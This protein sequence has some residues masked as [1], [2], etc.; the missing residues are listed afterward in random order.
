MTNI[1]ITKFGYGKVYAISFGHFIHDIYTSFLAPVLPLL[2]DKLKINYT[3]AALLTVAMRLPSLFNAFAGLLADKISFR[4]MVILA[5]AFSGVIMS[6]LGLAPNYIVLLL[7]LFF[8]GVSSTVFH[9]PTPVMIKKALPEKIGFGMSMYMLGGE[10]ARTFGPLTIIA[11]ISLWG[12]ENA[13]KLV[14]LAIL[15][16]ALLWFKLKDFKIYK[17]KEERNDLVSVKSVLKKYK[18]FFLYISGF[19]LFISFM[20]ASLSIFLPTFITDQGNSLWVGGINLAIY[21][22]AGAIGT[23]T[24][25]TI[26]DKI[27]RKNTLLIAAISNPLLM[28]VYVYFQDTAFSYIFLALLGLTLVSSGSVLLAMVQ[29][30]PSDRPA[31]M[32]GIYMTINFF[33]GSLGAVL[34]GYIGDTYG[35]ENT[36]YLSAIFAVI[37]IP[38]L[39]KLP[40]SEKIFY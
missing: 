4:Y 31:F 2:I 11:A 25:G 3:L 21:Q 32:N 19:M 28:L 40:K 12:F 30:I 9:V 27:G 20:K 37:A 34:I 23:F 33:V 38:F 15:T 17:K 18:L 10:L 24:S 13:Y 39:M 35:L 6:L 22:F 29:D 7:M 16:S 26:S 5:P 14:P 8:V 1:P 36:F